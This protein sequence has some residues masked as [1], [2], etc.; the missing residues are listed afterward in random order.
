MQAV[1]PSIHVRSGALL[2][3]RPAQD[4][5]EVALVLV[6]TGVLTPHRFALCTSSDLC[7][8]HVDD[9]QTASCISSAPCVLTLVEGD[10][11]VSQIIASAILA[12]ILPGPL[13]VTPSL[14]AGTG[15]AQGV[16]IEAFLTAAL[17]LTGAFALSLRL[18]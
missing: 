1:V 15:R 5:S 8:S 2:V 18:G 9:S 12:G 3:L 17:C 6:V 16:F 10:P 14:G 11:E 13:A 7:R 4:P